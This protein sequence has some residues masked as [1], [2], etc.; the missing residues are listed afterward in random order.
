MLISAL[1]LWAL[2][3]ALGFKI[4]RDSQFAAEHPAPGQLIATPAGR[5]HA[6]VRGGTGR[7]VI[8]V[9]GNPGLGLDFAPV[10]ERLPQDLKLIAVDRP[11]YGWSDR[12]K[13]SMT[14]LEQAEILRA[15][16]RSLGVEKPVLVGF[17][18]GGPVVLAWA[19][20]HPTEVSAVVLLAAVADP[21]DAHRMGL[22]QSLLAWPLLGPLMSRAVAPWVG[23]SAVE[24]GYVEAFFPLPAQPEVIARGQAHFTRPVTLEASAHDWQTL[25]GDLKQLEDG[26]RAITVPLEALYANQ[27]RVVGPSHGKFVEA[28]VPNAHVEYLEHAGHQLM[29]THTAQVVQAVERAL[30][31]SR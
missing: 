4:Y 30:N 1:V 26:C 3:T 7:P 5:V 16:M 21:H 6:S 10:M 8:F 9:H 15:A 2:A 31:R 19:R 18:F 28:S 29:S 20:A 23:P 27:D 13:T 17:S 14:P 24:H 12:P 25:N 22:G 11:G